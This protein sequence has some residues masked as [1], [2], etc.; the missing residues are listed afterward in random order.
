[1]SD[2][3]LP[4]SLEEAKAALETAGTAVAAAQTAIEAAKTAKDK[5]AAEALGY[6]AESATLLAQAFVEAFANAPATVFEAVQRQAEAEGKARELEATI[7]DLRGAE[8]SEALSMVNDLQ[9]QAMAWQAVA[10][11]PAPGSDGASHQNESQAKAPEGNAVAAPPQE[12]AD[13]DGSGVAS[14][15]DLRGEQ[16]VVIIDEAFVDGGAG[17]AEPLEPGG[18]IDALLDIEPE[19][20]DRAAELMADVAKGEITFEDV[21]FQFDPLD[22]HLSL[23]KSGSDLSDGNVIT[24]IGPPQGRRRAGFWFGSEPRTVTVDV[25]QM[26]LIKNDPSLSFKI[27]VQE[28]GGKFPLFDRSSRPTVEDLLDDAGDPVPVTVLGPAAGRRRAGRQFTAEPVTFLPT[29]EQLEQLVADLQL[30]IAPA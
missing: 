2:I 4:K 30:S 8:K 24:V 16:G 20:L 19:V 25:D 17:A 7:P 28:L 26:E 9:R 1:M 29:R 27:G 13:T 6:E 11:A 12:S 21:D 18:V 10:G 14:G 23:K 3:V 15:A 5:K 22:G